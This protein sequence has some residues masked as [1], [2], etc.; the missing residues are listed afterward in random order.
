MALATKTNAQ[1]DAAA[2]AVVAPYGP[3]TRVSDVET[4]PTPNSNIKIEF[5][6]ALSETVYLTYDEL[7][8][9][10][11]VTK[12]LESQ[13]AV[14]GVNAQMRPVYGAV[15]AAAMYAKS[16]AGPPYADTEW[17]F[18]IDLLRVIRPIVA[19]QTNYDDDPAAAIDLVGGFT[20]NIAG[21]PS[22]VVTDTSTGDILA[23]VWDWGDGEYSVGEVP[24]AHVYDT[25]AT[26]TITQII[27]GRAGVRFY[28]QTALVAGA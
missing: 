14:R 22:I 8:D 3:L 23:W 6:S 15:L 13:H 25:N 1:V 9:T 16:Y 12:I 24:G 21:D 27:V 28:T 7:V 20:V 26:F 2:A 5:T 18:I 19:Q 10:Q 4:F 11:L 17:Q